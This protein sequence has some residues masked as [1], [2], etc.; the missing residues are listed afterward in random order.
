MER[1]RTFGM[2]LC[3]NSRNSVRDC[4]GIHWIS[5]KDLWP[6]TVGSLMPVSVDRIGL[7]WVC[8]SG[9]HS[10]T[11]NCLHNLK[12]CMSW[13]A[14]L[15]MVSLDMG[16]TRKKEQNPLHIPSVARLLGPVGCRHS[17]KSG[18]IWWRD[19]HSLP[20]NLASRMSAWGVEVRLVLNVF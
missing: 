4:L 9:K 12:R 5:T 7:S 16:T 1:A 13:Q 14:S 8:S 6:V 2:Y 11:A 17:C 15:N 10:L 3:C 19:T 20:T 18:I